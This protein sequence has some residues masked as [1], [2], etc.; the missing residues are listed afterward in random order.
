M[1]DAYKLS[2]IINI[3]FRF[4][5]RYLA[6]FFLDLPCW[7]A[8]IKANSAEMVGRLLKRGHPDPYLQCVKF[9]ILYIKIIIIII[10]I[11]K[12]VLTMERSSI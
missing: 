4:F 8:Y 5:Y 9:S 12:H 1:C 3:T 7:D 6:V 11:T 2:L 10:I